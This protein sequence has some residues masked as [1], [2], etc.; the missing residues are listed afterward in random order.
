MRLKSNLFLLTS[1]I[2]AFL[3][4]AFITS[5]SQEQVKAA[6]THVVISQ[7]Q[8]SGTGNAQDEFVELY[9]PTDTPIEMT[10]WRL[11]RKSSSGGSIQNLVA[12][13][14]GTIAPRSYYLISHPS[15]STASIADKVY[16]SSSSAMT[17]NNTISL[18]SDAGVTIVD[19]IGLGTAVDVESSAFAT[20]PTNDQSIVRKATADSTEASLHTG[21]AEANFGNGFDT[22]TNETDFVLFTTSLPRNASSPQAQPQSTSTPVVTVTP[23]PTVFVT[24]T[25]TVLPSPTSPLPTT[26]PTATPL[27]TLLPT[28]VPS[29]TPTIAPT[30]IPTAIPTPTKTPTPLPTATPTTAPS[31]TETVAPTAVPTS[32]PTPTPA[33]TAMPTITPT[34]T[35]AGQVIVDERLSPTRR[36][37]CIQT[38]RQIRIFGY[39]FSF[40]SIKCSI[41][42]N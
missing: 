37:V 36:L 35:P 4:I 24:A 10:G 17:T 23:S 3:V 5:A 25:P 13:L 16:S 33:P 18:F 42:R 38:L 30:A 6:T 1:F 8:L 20:N 19:K 40:P 11:T 32:I 22:D 41:V 39:S 9:N 27:P 34:P 29:P 15:A 7:I 26:T 12:N 2:Y 28:T 21:G 31:P 14:S